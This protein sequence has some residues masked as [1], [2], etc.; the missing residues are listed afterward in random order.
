M[1]GTVRAAGLAAAFATVAAAGSAA[2]QTAPSAAAAASLTMAVAAPVTSL[3]PHYHQLSP[4]NAVADMVFDRLVGLDAQSR[5]VPGLAAEWRAVEPNVWEFKLRPGVRFHN[6]SAFTAEDVAFTLERVPNVPNS[7]TSFGVYTRPIR[8]VEIVDPLTIRMRTEGPYP[9]LPLD[10]T[11]IRVLDKETHQGGATEDFNSGRLAVGTGPYRVVSHR[12]GDRIELERNDAYWGDKPAY[13]RVT[14]RMIT[15]DASRTA[16]L[17]AGDVDFIDQVATS[18]VSRLRSDP[19]MALSEVTGLRIIYLGLDHQR[20]DASPFALDNS[21]QPIP[22]NPLK[23]VRVRRALSLAIDRPAIVERVM[24][25][26]ATPAGQ[27]FPPGVFSYVPELTPPRPDPEAARRLLAE[28]GFPQGFRLTLHGPNDRYIND[29]RIIQAVGQMWTRV[30]VRTAVEAQ[31]WTTFVARAGR[32][33]FSAF[34][35]GWGSSPEGS[36]PLRNLVATWDRERGW[37]ASNRGRYSN[38]EIDRLIETALAE[39][40]DAKRE[41]ILQDAQRRAFEDVAIVPL[42]I[43][44]NI[45]AMRRGVQHTARVDELTRAQDVRPAAAAAAA[46]R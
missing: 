35:I 34:L 20:T 25:G 5:A 19:K 10:M 41:K 24:E 40:D 26:A 2:A 36:H 32:Q 33:E 23:D 15:N 44:T 42:H 17:L 43:Q 14:Y 3:D 21:G 31:P 30:G 28:A 22:R 18:D 39:L 45:W 4:N 29:A 6:G 37:G 11:H 46:A 27:F 1:K 38:P 12:N 13:A 7:P 8:T 9:L 16:A